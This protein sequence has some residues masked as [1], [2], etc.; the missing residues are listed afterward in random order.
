MNDATPTY[1][2]PLPYIAT[3]KDVQEITLRG[4]ADGAFWQQQLAAV[5]LRPIVREGLA[6]VSLSSIH[7]R[8]LGWPFHELVI[9]IAVE[10]QELEAP[11]GA[12][13]LIH[14]FNSSRVLGW[15][16]RNLFQTPYYHAVI[17]N[18]VEPPAKIQASIGGRALLDVTM[19]SGERTPIGSQHEAWAGPIFLPSRV[20]LS[21]QVF[22]AD[23]SGTTQ[24]YPFLPGEDRIEIQ[25]DKSTPVAGW[26]LESQFT[27][28]QWQLRTSAIHARTKTMRRKTAA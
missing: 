16:E 23:L 21:Q 10:P 7:G 17:E 15:M 12:L 1:R 9:V 4:Q 19:T 8:F 5:D 20:T 24:A 22:F 28:L 25:A 26:L 3:I 18:A 13:Y 27:G 2:P 11:Q 14:A 6:E